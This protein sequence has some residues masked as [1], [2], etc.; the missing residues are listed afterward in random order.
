MKESNDSI[1]ADFVV[2][3]L[4][5]QKTK[6]KNPEKSRKQTETKIFCV[7]CVGEEQ[8]QKFFAGRSLHL[9]LFA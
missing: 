4:R 5:N 2:V 8:Q 3:V 6:T 9:V 1:P 7:G